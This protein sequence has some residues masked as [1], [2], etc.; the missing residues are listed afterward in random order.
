MAYQPKELICSCIRFSG[1]LKGCQLIE[2]E[3][4]REGKEI[5]EEGNSERKREKHNIK[6]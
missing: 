5:E 2:R 1:K 6:T 4:E 3:Q